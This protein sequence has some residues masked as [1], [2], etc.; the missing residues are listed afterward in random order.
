M[1]E[2]DALKAIMSLLFITNLLLAFIAGKSQE[3]GG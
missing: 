1:T 2:L 3:G